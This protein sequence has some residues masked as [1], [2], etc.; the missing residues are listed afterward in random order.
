MPR[1][2]DSAQP[3]R[4]DFTLHELTPAEAKKFDHHCRNTQF[5]DKEFKMTD[6]PVSRQGVLLLIRREIG[7]SGAPAFQRQLQGLLKEV[8]A[9]PLVKK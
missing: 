8:Q 6:E 1:P 7:R 2:D 3:M 4:E 5:D 9:M